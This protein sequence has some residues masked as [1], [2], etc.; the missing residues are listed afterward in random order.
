MKKN[1]F[2]LLLSMLLAIATLSGCATTQ[3][4]PKES[5]EPPTAQTSARP[6]NQILFTGSSTIAPIIQTTASTFYEKN[7][8]WDKVDG[9]LPKSNIEIYVSS[10]GSGVGTA[11]MIDGTADFGMVAREVKKE[12]KEA[13]RDEKEFKI[14]IDALT[15]AVNPQNPVTSTQ[16][17]LSKDQIIKLF[18]GEYKKWNDLDPTLPNEDIV[19]ITRDLNGG[20]H[21]VFQ[22]K[23]MGDVDVTPNSIQASSMGELVQDI[24]DNPHAIG[25]ASFGVASRNAGKV[26]PL[27][28]DGIEASEANI[29]DGSYPIQRP[30]LLIASGELSKQEQAFLDTIQGEAGQKIISQLGFIPVKVEK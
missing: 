26:A 16:N 28:V 30:L 4:A 13:I 22:Q 17:D 27:K 24:I 14:G 18:S 10:G 23:I 1:Y 3:P 25:Y 2:V 15:I 20:A 8:T 11:A 21:E 7:K 9:S 5:G 19:V 12:E 6:A 29:L